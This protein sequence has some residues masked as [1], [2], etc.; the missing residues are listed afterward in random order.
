[1]TITTEVLLLKEETDILMIAMAMG[2]QRETTIQKSIIMKVVQNRMIMLM[3]IIMKAVLGEILVIQKKVMDLILVV[4]SHLL[5]E[6]NAIVKT[7]PSM[8]R[9]MREMMMRWSVSSPIQIHLETLKKM[10]VWR[11]RT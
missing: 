5:K 11:K 2:L 9:L 4:M 10:E 6:V 7:N 3:T 1:M 8:T